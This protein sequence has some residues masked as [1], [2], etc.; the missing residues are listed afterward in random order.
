MGEPLQTE[1][2]APARLASGNFAFDRH[3]T[4]VAGGPMGCRRVHILEVAYKRGQLQSSDRDVKRAD[5]RLQAGLDFA[6][7]FEASNF[8][9]GKDSTVA[10]DRIS[11]SSGSGT[12]SAI[13]IDAQ[14]RLKGYRDNPRL[15]FMNFQLLEMVCGEQQKASE[16]VSKLF[17]GDYTDSTWPRI[18]EALDSL[19]RAS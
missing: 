14:R 5:D 6:S 7:T 17:A 15:G 11:G 3:L 10:L 1:P 18:R 4:K 2:E 9:P 13:R 16:A 12:A 8:H 19:I